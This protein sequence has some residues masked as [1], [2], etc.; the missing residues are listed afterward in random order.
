MG[1]TR[2][3]GAA[4]ARASAPLPPPAA[5]MPEEVDAVDAALITVGIGVVVLFGLVLVVLARHDRRT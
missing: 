1:L 3:S 4:A 5:D 2:S